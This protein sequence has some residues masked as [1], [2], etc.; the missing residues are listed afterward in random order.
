MRIF[1]ETTVRKER[2]D[3]DEDVPANWQIRKDES[4]YR[5]PE[6][7]TGFCIHICSMETTV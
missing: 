4:Y 5:L 1:G 6:S 7:E 2:S 3:F